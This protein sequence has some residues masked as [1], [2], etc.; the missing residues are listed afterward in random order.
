MNPFVNP[1]KRSIALPAGCKDLI[2]VLQMAREELE[3]IR[4]E[5]LESSGLAHVPR[6]VTKVIESLAKSVT[7]YIGSLQGKHA[8][9]V[10][11]S[12]SEFSIIPLMDMKVREKAVEE[13]FARKGIE[14]SADFLIGQPAKT[15][16]ILGFPMPGQRSD[17]VALTIDLLREV[18]EFDDESGME[19]M[20]LE[21][22]GV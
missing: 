6:Y 12:A 17:A 11:R 3:I 21:Y 1:N 16:R 9:T 20:Y 15:T 8:I 4:P 18:Y 14:A 7:L 13:F 19:F 22:N 5:R 2:D 10:H